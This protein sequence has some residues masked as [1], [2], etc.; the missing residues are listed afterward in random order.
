MVWSPRRPPEFS[1]RNPLPIPERRR[2]GRA[3]RWC[4][5]S[6][7]SWKPDLSEQVKIMIETLLGPPH[8]ATEAEAHR[9][10]AGYIG[11]DLETMRAREELLTADQ[12]MTTIYELY[13]L[14]QD[15]AGMERTAGRIADRAW[16]AELAYRDIHPAPH[17]FPDS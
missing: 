6:P 4:Y 8:S 11:M 13:A 5:P 15:T 16:A 14:R 12:R 3:W 7:A 9:V 1:P 10:R 17:F 2:P